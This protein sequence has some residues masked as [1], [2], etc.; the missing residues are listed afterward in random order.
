MERSSFN[1]ETPVLTLLGSVTWGEF[2]SQLVS[3][4]VAY[5]ERHPR[6]IGAAVLNAPAP[7]PPSSRYCYG[8]K[9]IMDLFHV[10]NMTAQKYKRTIIKDAVKQNGRKIVVDA[11]KALAL[12]AQAQQQEVK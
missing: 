3:E 1:P 4:F 5:L 11:E 12:F 10:S 7:T 2:S 9:G 6:T 8:L